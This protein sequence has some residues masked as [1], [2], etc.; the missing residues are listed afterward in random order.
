MPS[1]MNQ[2]SELPLDHPDR[3]RP[4]SGCWYRNKLGGG[5]KQVMPAFKIAKVCYNL[6]GSA[7]TQA[8]EFY[9][10]KPHV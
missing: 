7:W 5:W 4:L 1:R 8:N 9:W 10:E 6:L 3:N 2:L